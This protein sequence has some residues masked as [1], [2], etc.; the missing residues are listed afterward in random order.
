MI[1]SGRVV[2]GR[3]RKERASEIGSTG[4]CAELPAHTSRPPRSGERHDRD[5]IT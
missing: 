2:R 5:R 3:Y 1:P 4:G